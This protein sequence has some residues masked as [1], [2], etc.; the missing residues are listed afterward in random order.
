MKNK[1]NYSNIL[2]DHEE[3][4]GTEVYSGLS[5]GKRIL[6]VVI[7]LILLGAL[8]A[9][10]IYLYNEQLKPVNPN[11]TTDTYVEIPSGSSIKEVSEILKEN[12]L[13]RNSLVFTSYAGRHS[14]GGAEIQAATYAL[15]QSM[16]V[17]DIFTIL[18]NGDQYIA[19]VATITIPEGKN[20][21]EMAQ[22][23]E[24]AGICSADEFIQEASDINKYKATYSILDSIP[25]EEIP[26]RT[27][28][29]YLFPDTYEIVGNGIDAAQNLINDQLTRLTEVYTPEMI[30]YTNDTGRT[31]DEVIILASI[32]ELE[33]KLPEDRAYAASVFYNRLAQ[34]MPLQSDITI[35]YIYGTR[36]PVLTTEQT[37][38]ESPYNTYINLG[39]PL[40]PICSPGLASI[41]AT[42]YPADT[43]YLYFVADMDSGKLYFN[44]TLEEH[45]EDVSTYLE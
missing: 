17:P 3:Y 43:N 6:G 39:L 31:V 36:T 14:F 24:E 32:V 45:D 27:L 34:D 44:E 23:V 28:E 16:S 21:N 42:I 38:V 2:E 8:I 4:D 35:D 7:I 9:G 30:Q 13:I 12:D 29:G 11:N 20:L 41:E 40:G 19:N 26:E 10:G 5:V 33:T 18:V 1:N 22:I 15:N 25:E 37:Q